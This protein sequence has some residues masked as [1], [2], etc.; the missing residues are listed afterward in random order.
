MQ[1]Q[2]HKNQNQNPTQILRNL[3]QIISVCYPPFQL[4]NILKF[5]TFH[6]TFFDMNFS[7]GSCMQP[8]MHKNSLS[9]H[10][11]LLSSLTILELRSVN[12]RSIKKHFFQPMNQTMNQMTSVV[13]VGS[14]L[15]TSIESQGY[16][17]QGRRNWGGAWGD[18]P[19]RFWTA[20]HNTT[21]PPGF[22]DLPTV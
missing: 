16:V 19:F 13:Y 14:P 12:M 7:N 4:H 15:Q 9:N 8:Q 11:G 1:P 17:K 20:H 22:S 2:M 21:R 10:F 6:K 18:R 5:H 3:F